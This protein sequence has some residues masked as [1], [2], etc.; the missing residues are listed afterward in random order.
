MWYFIPQTNE[1][2]VGYTGVSRRSVRWL[3]CLFNVVSQTPPTLFK[4]SKWNFER[5]GQRVPDLC[6]FFP[7]KSYT[8]IS[9]FPYFLWHSRYRGVYLLQSVIALVCVEKLPTSSLF[10]SPNLPPGSCIEFKHDL[11]SRTLSTSPSPYMWYIM[12]LLW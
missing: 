7:K 11:I 10:P 5:L 8:C 1:I 3:V 2:R 6:P 9:I 12:K 4:E